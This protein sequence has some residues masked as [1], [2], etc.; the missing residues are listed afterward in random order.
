VTPCEATIE[1]GA[2]LEL[3]VLFSPDHASDSFWNL[4]EVSVPNQEAEPHLLMLRGRAT[5][6][7]GY[8]LA[9]EQLVKDGPALLGVPPRDLLGLPTGGEAAGE[10]KDE[11]RQIEI[12][13]VPSG[14]E[15]VGS[16]E[17]VIGHAKANKLDVKP[18]PLEF[19]FEGLDDEASRRGFSVEPLKG[20]VKEGEQQ[21]VTLS[22]AQKEEA[23]AGTELGVIASFGVS[24]WAEVW[25]KCVLKG[26]N[27]LPTQ[28]ETTV[29]LKGYIAGRSVAS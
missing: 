9:P 12:S 3:T 11:A 18:A 25:L 1:G 8:V 2:S 26:G 24:Q 15:G 7:A 17:L 29:L 27:P 20:V 14:P 28:P 19:S 22:F 6:C 5:A 16:A 23:L 4:V 10:P 21:I 13:L